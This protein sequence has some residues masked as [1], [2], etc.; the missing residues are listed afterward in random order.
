MCG[1]G[2]E[3]SEGRTTSVIGGSSG[4]QCSGSPKQ[5]ILEQPT[6]YTCTHALAHTLLYFSNVISLYTINMLTYQRRSNTSATTQLSIAAAFLGCL[7]GDVDV[8]DD[9]PLGR[10]FMIAR[11]KLE[12]ERPATMAL[13]ARTR[14]A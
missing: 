8:D 6:S 4:R 1:Y 9:H 3:G 11:T 2:D 13:P 10:A 5:R 12:R 14:V 7:F